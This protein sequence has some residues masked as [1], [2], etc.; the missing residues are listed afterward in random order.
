MSTSSAPR[1]GRLRPGLA[2]LERARPRV[3]GASTRRHRDDAR[4]TADARRKDPFTRFETRERARSSRHAQNR[5]G[6]ISASSTTSREPSRTRFGRRNAVP[7]RRAQYENRRSER[8]RSRASLD[9]RPGTLDAVV[10]DRPRALLRPQRQPAPEADRPL[11]RH[12]DPPVGPCHGAKSRASLPGRP[13]TLQ[14]VRY[15]SDKGR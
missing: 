4:H 15:A 14:P 13:R 12:D 8:A 6:V 9:G 5:I 1:P 10:R 2:S 3:C 11:G 7:V